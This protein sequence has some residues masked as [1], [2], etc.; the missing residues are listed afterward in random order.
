[1]TRAILL[2]LVSSC[3]A[4]CCESRECVRT[5]KITV[6]NGDFGDPTIDGFLGT[7]HKPRQVDHCVEWRPKRKA[8]E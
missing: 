3:S 1:M 5:E 7:Q 8:N 4:E 6:R 2:L